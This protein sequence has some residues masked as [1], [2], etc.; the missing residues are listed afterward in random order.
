M[1]RTDKD[2]PY[3][4][5]ENLYPAKYWARFGYSGVG[6]PKWYINHVWNAP[7]RLS[8]RVDCDKAKREFNAGVVPEIEPSTRQHRHCA[9]WLYW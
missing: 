1:S 9:Q 4:I 5:R 7:E 3:R 8:S 6:V 2:L